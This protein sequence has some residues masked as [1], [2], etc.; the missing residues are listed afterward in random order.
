[1]P[2]AFEWAGRSVENDLGA[3]SPEEQMRNWVIA[4]NR[5]TTVLKAKGYPYQLLRGRGPSETVSSSIDRWA[6]GP[7]AIKT[8][9]IDGVRLSWIR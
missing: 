3:T 6:P 9:T 7:G 8:A 1:M 4:N 2:E 5:M